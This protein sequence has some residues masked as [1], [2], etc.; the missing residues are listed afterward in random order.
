MRLLVLQESDWIERG[1]HQ[2]HHLLERLVQKGHRVRVVDFEIGWRSRGATRL[3]T[4]RVE[5]VVTG[6]VVVGSKVEVVRPSVVHLPLLDYASLVVTHSLEIRRQIREFRPDIVLGL[7]LL[8]TF[9]GIHFARKARIPFVSFVIDELHRL[10]RERALQGVAR[11][12]EQ[13]NIR[14]ATIVLSINERLSDYTIA[15][16]AR[17]QSA[18]VVPAGVDLGWIAS[19][20]GPSIRQRH[21]IKNEDL[22]LLFMGWVYPFSGVQDVAQSLVGAELTDPRVTLLVVGKGDSWADIRRLVEESRAADRIKLVDFRP[23]DEIPSYLAASDI[24]ILPARDVETMRNIVPIKMYE[25]LGAGKPVI[26]TRLPG[27]LSEFGE[28]HGVVYVDTPAEVVAR[29][30]A[31]FRQGDLRKLGVAGRDFVSRNDWVRITDTFESWLRELVEQS[32]PL[33]EARP[34]G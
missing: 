4:N 26:A 21:G 24:C 17:P 28:D 14:R 20:N 23:Y 9:A 19:G 33:A 30:I 29:A 1:P 32:K 3:F 2:S 5:S 16:G 34:A 8:N 15:M 27:L 18:R 6:K 25:Y 31:L 13:S 11:V 12:L 10:V 7:G 22:L